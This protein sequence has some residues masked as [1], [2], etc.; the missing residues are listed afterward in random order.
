MLLLSV[1]LSQNL[2]SIYIC[3]YVSL[4]LISRSVTVALFNVIL[5]RKLNA[6]RT[7]WP[8][9]SKTNMMYLCIKYRNSLNIS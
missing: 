4:I 2:I 9:E 1:R 6:R 3:I 5:K 7:F 8:G